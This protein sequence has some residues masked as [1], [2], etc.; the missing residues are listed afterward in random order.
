MKILAA[1]AYLDTWISLR[2][3]AALFAGLV[4]RGHE[5]TVATQ[6]HESHRRWLRD[7]GVRILDV[8]PRRKLSLSA[9]RAYRTELRQGAYDI[10]YGMNSRTISNLAVALQG[11]PTRFVTYR[12]TASGMYRRDP[13]SY[14]THLHPRVD[15]ICCVS[16][17]VERVVRQRVWRR[18][19]IVS[20]VYKGHDLDWFPPATA[21]LGEFG[22]PAGAF[23]IACIANARPHKGLSLLLAAAD[24]VLVHPEVHLLLIGRGVSA[25]P[26]TGLREASRWKER[27]HLLGHRSDAASLLAGASLYVQ[28]SR[29][30]EGLPKTVIE[31]MAQSV[32]AI[33]SD[34]GG[35]PELVVHGESG[36]VVARDSLPQL[37]DALEFAYEQRDLLPA[38][39]ASARERI[40]REFSTSRTVEGHISLFESLLG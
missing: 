6:G 1:S 18:G 3:E 16:K 32:P 27:I 21:S 34:A 4:A 35:M 36:W 11:L 28:P 31:A 9:I 2:P 5:V 20:T 12:G 13:T 10:A 19:V 17:A 25:E 30:G 29:S 24:R 7:A 14:L 39:G 38:M 37:A 8:Y 40:G 22:I 26:Y 33:V 15:A 23:V